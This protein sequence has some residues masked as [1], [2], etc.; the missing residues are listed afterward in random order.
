MR[1]ALRHLALLLMLLGGSVGL[2][3]AT[4]AIAGF[5]YDA[6]PQ[7]VAGTRA[8]APVAR[9]TTTPP[10]VRRIAGTATRRGSQTLPRASTS[11]F[12]P[13]RAAK[14]EGALSRLGSRL[15]DETGSFSPF[16]GRGA[17]RLTNSQATDLADWLG[18]R[19][20]GQTLR[21]EK[22]FTNGK[23]F[24]VQDTTSHSGGVWKMAK[25]PE[26]LNSRTSR[27]GTYDEQL[28]YIGP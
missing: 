7:V 26:A 20:T 13:R 22:V 1:P 23:Q 16:A 4:P 8:G 2:L 9:T 6:P 28:N 15:A 3:E 5:H 19:S 12:L 24:I 17:S 11:S 18:Y 27:M 21:G 10:A 25:S 14:G